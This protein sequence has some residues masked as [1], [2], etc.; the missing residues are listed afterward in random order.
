MTRIILSIKEENRLQ[1]RVTFLLISHQFYHNLRP[2]INN[3]SKDDNIHKSKA[4]HT[5]S[6]LKSEIIS[7]NKYLVDTLSKLYIIVS[8]NIQHSS[9]RI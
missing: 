3:L 6:K 8:R 2:V 4:K 7:G 9:K 1:S 5:S